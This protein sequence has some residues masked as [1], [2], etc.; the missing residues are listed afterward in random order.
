MCITKEEAFGDVSSWENLLSALYSVTYFSYNSYSKSVQPPA[1]QW[2]KVHIR[3]KLGR[4]LR[5]FCSSPRK[6]T[7]SIFNPGSSPSAPFPFDDPGLLSTACDPAYDSPL[8]W[9]RAGV[10]GT[11]TWV[12]EC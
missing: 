2:Q 8:P 11:G 12:R 7:L 3:S 5:P 6:R 9:D 4:L 1:H 10:S